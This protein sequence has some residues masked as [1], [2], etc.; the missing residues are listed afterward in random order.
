MSRIGLIEKPAVWAATLGPIVTFVGYTIA[1]SMWE[2]YDGVKKT[3]SDLAADDSPVQLFISIVFLFGALCD[4]V[5]S[6]YAKAFATA[7]RIVTE[8]PSLRGASKPPRN[9]TSSSLI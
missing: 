9:R 6:H 4:I 1:G 2:G 7:G 5:I 8:S 3:I